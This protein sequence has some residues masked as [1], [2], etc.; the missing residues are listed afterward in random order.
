MSEPRMVTPIS[1]GGPHE[2][3]MDLRPV[4]QGI[5]VDEPEVVKD[6]PKEI[7]TSSTE[8]PAVA[9][10]PFDVDEKKKSPTPGSAT[11]TAEATP[12]NSSASPAQLPPNVKNTEGPTASDTDSGGVTTT[13]TGKPLAKST[14]PMTPD[15]K[16]TLTPP[17]LP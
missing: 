14:T 10:L 8:Q 12:E 3:A 4:N 13:P 9:K 7:S 15:S 16:K 17:I 1:F 5:T 6:G 2:N 11:S